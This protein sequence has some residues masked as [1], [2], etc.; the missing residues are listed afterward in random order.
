MRRPSDR[1]P[2]K[3][4]WGTF[5]P[6]RRKPVPP[7]MTQAQWRRFQRLVQRAEQALKE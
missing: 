1:T 4:D 3:P 5:E 6:V 2:R 7:G